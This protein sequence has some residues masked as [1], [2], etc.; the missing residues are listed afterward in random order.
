MSDYGYEGSAFDLEKLKRKNKITPMTEEKK[1]EKLMQPRYKVIAD[2]PGR[3][4]EMNKALSPSGNF[5]KAMLDQYPHLYKKL[6]W[7]AEREESEMEEVKYA[8]TLA[9][10]SVRTVKGFELQWDKIILDGGKIRPI[11]HWLPA[12][13]KEYTEYIN[14]QKQSAP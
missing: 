5:H 7:W 12:T 3:T 8:K 4:M 10:N 1:I 14:K 9:G 6:E 2:Y 11:K 13:E